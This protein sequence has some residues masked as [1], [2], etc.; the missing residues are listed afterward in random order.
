M[1]QAEKKDLFTDEKQ[2]GILPIE[3]VTRSLPSIQSLQKDLEEFDRA[4]QLNWLMNHEPK[5]QWVKENPMAN[6]TKYIP[7]GII[8]NLLQRIF[9]QIRIEVIET[10]NMFNAVAVTI[11]L[12]YLNPINN[13]W[14]YHDGVGAVELQTKQGTGPVKPDFS[15][16]NRGAV[17][18]ALPMA[19]SYA[20]KDAAEHLGKLFGRDISRKEVIEYKSDKDYSNLEG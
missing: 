12:H 6:N 1:E 17:M 15:N 7:I 10:K 13:E 2:G 18:M 14:S 4:D 19:K 5:K 9:K 8:E 11:R 20:L 16:I 3:P